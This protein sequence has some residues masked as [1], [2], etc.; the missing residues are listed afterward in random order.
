M[1]A[2]LVAKR[3]DAIPFGFGG[4]KIRK[5]TLVAAEAKALG[6]D[7]LIT[8]GG[9]QSN[10]CR[11]TASAAAK[12][13]MR[14]HLVLNGTEPEAPSGNLTLDHL[15]GATLT[16]VAARPDRAPTMERVAQE[17]RD[18]G[19]VPYLIPL[20]ASTPLGAMALARGVG[21]MVAQGIV[22]DVIV[23]SSSSGGTQAGLVAGCALY[24]VRTRVIGV[25]A[26]DPVAEIR[27]KVLGIVAGVEERLGL[28]PG[29]LGA[30]ERFT[31][32]AGYVGEGYGIATDASREAQSLAARTEAI[33]TDH[34]YTA[35][36]LAGLIGR[37]RAG[38]FKDGMTVLF[39]HT[40]GQVGV[41]A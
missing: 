2:R 16:Y 34:W 35:K 18:A 20:G 25:S 40:G 36:A 4:N 41:F 15:L 3:D 33:V 7:T 5:L 19:G 12:L 11:A 27:T 31:A 13:G 29:S 30:A 22:P 26:D 1:G 38:E 21:E 6:A 17:V 28:S 8:C 32:D 37:A 23:S 10:H 24:G 39:W 9:L 14:C